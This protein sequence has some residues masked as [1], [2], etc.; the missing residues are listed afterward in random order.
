MS[1]VSHTLMT[2]GQRFSVNTSLYFAISRAIYEFTCPHISTEMDSKVIEVAALGRPL[3][4]GMLYDCRSD[5]FTPG[6]SLWDEAAI[7]RDMS[8]KPQP[9]SSFHFTAFDSL[10]EKANL[11]DVSA[12]LKA[13]FLGGLVEVGG[14]ASYL[15]DRA[16]SMH[17]CR[18][19]MQYK[20]TTEF[21]QLTMTQLGKVTYPQVFDQKTATHV[22]TAVLYGAEAFMVFDQMASDDKENKISR[23]TWT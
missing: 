6:V 21:K 11:L 16:S 5:T 10:S 9:R 17:Q 14:S 7:K 22:V 23:G 2:E 3:H 1:C 12:S 20:Q 19:T 13:S 8:V 4:P 18:V 15:N